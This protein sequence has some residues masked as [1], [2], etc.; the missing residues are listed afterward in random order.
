MKINIRHFSDFHY[1]AKFADDCARVGKLMAESTKD[2]PV[3]II[4]F[5]GDLAQGVEESFS[6]AYNALIK[7]IQ[8]KHHLPMSQIL[9]VPGNHDVDKTVAQDSIET[10]AHCESEEQLDAFCTNQRQMQSSLTRMKPYRKFC[11]T[12]FGEILQDFVWGE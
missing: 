4:I 8:K 2:L 7:P 10:L 3:D 12:L 5:S 9:I 6:D 1:Q 11:K